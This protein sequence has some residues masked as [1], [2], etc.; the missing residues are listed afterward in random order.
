MDP[1]TTGVFVLIVL[2]VPVTADDIFFTDPVICYCLD[3][4]LVIYCI[5]ATALYFKEKFSKIPSVAAGEPD[6]NGCIYQELQRPAD[7]DPYEMLNISK[8]KKKAGKK[9]KSAPAPAEV[10]DQDPFESLIPSGSAPPPPLSP[11]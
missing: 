9:K 10:R 2:L 4:I 5:G 8:T 1:Q 11:R 3:T 7:T 6:D